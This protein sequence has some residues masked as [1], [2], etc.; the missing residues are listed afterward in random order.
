MESHE[1][2]V[3]GTEGVAEVGDEEVEDEDEYE[4]EDEDE[5]VEEDEDEDEDDVEDD[6]VVVDVDDDDDERMVGE[7]DELNS[8]C[9][10]SAKYIFKMK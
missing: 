5:E 1:G 6:E 3:G 8:K 2:E 4:D 9:K 7:N 10:V